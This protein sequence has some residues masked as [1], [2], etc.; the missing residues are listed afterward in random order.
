MMRFIKIAAAAFVLAAPIVAQDSALSRYLDGNR[1]YRDG[2]FSAA[3]AA[4]EDALASGANDYRV[5]YNLG[6]AYFR[7]DKIGKA[8]VSYER[9]R[10]LAPRNDDII[11]NLEFVR[12]T[13]VGI[14]QETTGKPGVVA[15]V[16]ENTVLGKVYDTL[17]LFTFGELAASIVIGSAVGA[18]F[19]GLWILVRSR[20]RKILL[21]VS[22]I[23]F[24]VALIMLVPY[25]V[26]RS[27]PWET[28]LAIVTSPRA[29]IH[30]APSKKSQ[31]KYTFL[32]GMEVAVK[33]ARGDYARVL[34]R[35][36]EEGWLL[37]ERIEAV[38]P[39]D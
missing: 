8:I 14:V 22:I 28:H 11:N 20:I 19:L 2:D 33:E 26:K 6:N 5:Y 39:P 1:A 9:A 38:L 32:E 37:S 30:S 24:G 15:D 25:A 36:G 10:Y 12:N 4:Y 21:A 7:L 17:G 3:T 27:Y 13:R 34:L 16:Y 18:L 31:L 23:A 35:N 29:E